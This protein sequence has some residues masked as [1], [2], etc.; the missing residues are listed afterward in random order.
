MAPE[1]K[2]SH[3]PFITNPTERTKPFIS[4]DLGSVPA[5]L[6]ESE[7]FG[8]EKGSFT[9]AKETRLEN[10]NWQIKEHC[11]WTRLE[12]FPRISRSNYSP[13]FKADPLAK[14]GSSKVVQLDVRIIC[15]TNAPIYDMVKSGTFRQDFFTGSKPLR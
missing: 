5:T 14:I 2:L 13:L 8:H 15:A 6:F 7:M 1:R 11:F 10:L 3:G 9:D 12:T 4:V